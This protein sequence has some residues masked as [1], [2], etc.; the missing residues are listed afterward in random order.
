MYSGLLEVYG[1][2]S[3][4]GQDAIHGYAK[5]LA[6]AMGFNSPEFLDLIVDPPPR[7]ESLLLLMLTVVEDRVPPRP[8]VDACLQQHEKTGDTR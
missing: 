6:E 4:E 1:E 2:T 3:E 8:I 5:P 7:C